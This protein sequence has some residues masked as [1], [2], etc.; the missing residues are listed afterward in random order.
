MRRW[1]VCAVLVAVLRPL[2]F[3][4]PR[5]AGRVQRRAQQNPYDVLGLGRT[6][7]YDDIR[8]AFR[9]LARKYHPDVPDTGDD[10]RFRDIREALEEL[11]T[12]EGRTRWARPS[13][14]QSS[15]SSYPR[16][17]PFEKSW[18]QETRRRWQEE[19]RARE[20][21]RR[22]QKQRQQQEKEEAKKA[23]AAAAQDTFFS[24]ELKKAVAHAQQRQAARRMEWKARMKEA[25]HKLREKLKKEMSAGWNII[26]D[27]E[28]QRG[29]EMR[30][31]VDTWSVNLESEKEAA[32]ARRAEDGKRW[33]E[34]FA[35]VQRKASH[36]QEEIGKLYADRLRAFREEFQQSRQASS[37]ERMEKIKKDIED[38]LDIQEERTSS[39]MTESYSS[40]MASLQRSMT[41]EPKIWKDTFRQALMRFAKGGNFVVNKKWQ[42][43]FQETMRKMGE[44]EMDEVSQ[45]IKDFNSVQKKE[46][47]S[48]TKLAQ[49]GQRLKKNVVDRRAYEK[50]LRKI[51][52]CH[53]AEMK[54][55]QWQAWDRRQ[56]LKK[57][58]QEEDRLYESEKEQ[59]LKQIQQ[60]WK[61]PGTA[62]RFKFF[63]NNV[64]WRRDE[65]QELSSEAGIWIPVKVSRDLLLREPDSSFEE[66][67]AR[68]LVLSAFDAM[69]LM[70]LMPLA[71]LAFPPDPSLR[72][73]RQTPNFPKAEAMTGL[74]ITHVPVEFQDMAHAVPRL[75]R[76][77]LLGLTAKVLTS[78]EKFDL[79]VEVGPG[80][81]EGAW[82]ITDPNKKL[83]AGKSYEGPCKD[84]DTVL[85]GTLNGAG[86]KPGTIKG[87]TVQCGLRTAAV[88]LENENFKGQVLL[89]YR[90]TEGL[91]RGHPYFEHFQSRKRNWELRLQGKFKKAPRGRLYVG[92]VLRDFNYDQPVASSSILAM[93]TAVALVKYQYRIYFS[94]GARCKEALRP[95]AELGH[96]VSDLTVWDQ[97]IITPNGRPVPHICD[98]LD[99]P[100]DVYGLSLMRRDVGLSEYSKMIQEIEGTLNTEDTYTFRLWGPA[101]F[102]D[103]LNWQL[104]IGARVSLDHF[105]KD[106]PIHVCM[107]DLPPHENGK[108]DEQ[109]LESKKRYYFDFM[110]WSN[111]VTISPVIFERYVFHNAPDGFVMQLGRQ[112]SNNSFHSLPSGSFMS[113]DSNANRP[114]WRRWID[115]MRWIPKS[116][117]I[118][119]SPHSETMPMVGE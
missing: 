107:Y 52:G 73:A 104:K 61:G 60:F 36:R 29:E 19:E 21:E 80:D 54:R 49:A 9:R 7:G 13:Q 69:P 67:L 84:L 63:W 75:R 72:G 70:P 85:N 10:D 17:D 76:S 108:S 93:N 110:G 96:T 46:S 77:V 83:K 58:R 59:E 68:S 55:L 94:W 25:A 3:A 41:G 101:P 117:C 16:T 102:L 56:W 103:V 50:I 23:R 47:K 87:R 12:P 86:R 112:F 37:P 105:M 4:S 98:D 31:Q 53:K 6:A 62:L 106:Y 79:V 33:V 30:K 90:P 97:I 18:K 115:R 43:Q 71:G 74:I 39:R 24:K 40:M 119:T 2:L 89:L 78:K 118:Y 88:P 113:A 44:K 48:R 116:T 35:E 42:Q 64:V 26:N 1:L 66:L 11:G 82:K 5:S 32:V 27:F 57:F 20:Q 99:D 38:I 45:W 28:Q 91:D 111:V 15:Y 65:V 109:H 114:F 95:N 51:D 8:A 14:A 81:D 34:K 92:A 100:S 22:W